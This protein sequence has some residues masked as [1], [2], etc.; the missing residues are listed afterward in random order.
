MWTVETL[1]HR[2]DGELL[3]LPKD[4]RAK[5]FRI[6]QMLQEFGPLEVRE[7]Y[8]KY[9]EQGIWEIR[10]RGRDGISRAL[11]LVERPKRLVVVRVFAKKSQTTPRKEIRIALNRAKEIG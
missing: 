1:D 6:A 3:A 9:V 2:V 5:F 8:V 10:M 11:Y 4:Q 7:P